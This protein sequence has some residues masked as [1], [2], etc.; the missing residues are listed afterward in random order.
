[1]ANILNHKGIVDY[2]RPAFWSRVI[3]NIFLVMA[4]IASMIQTPPSVV[5]FGITG[6]LAF[7]WISMLFVGAVTA[8]I[9]IITTNRLLQYLGPSFVI[10]SF[11]LWAISLMTRPDATAASF[12]VAFIF[13]SFVCMKICIMFMMPVSGTKTN[14]RL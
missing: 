3:G 13:F 12:T 8:I 4:G 9:G 14:A 11:V 1:M 6:F 2:P 10:G 5:S 7:I